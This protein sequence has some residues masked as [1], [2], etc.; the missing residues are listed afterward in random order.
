[1]HF[2]T[3]ALDGGPIIAQVAVPVASGDTP[4]TLAAR[5]LAEEHH[6]YPRVARWFLDGRLQLLGERAQLSGDAVSAM[7]L[8]SPT[9][10]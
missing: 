8:H 10:C 2:V 6:L 1:V 4:E 7:A 9:D 3:P 5:V